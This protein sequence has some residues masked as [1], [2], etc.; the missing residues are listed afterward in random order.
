MSNQGSG[1]LMQEGGGVKMS[2]KEIFFKYMV[3]LPW[4]IVCLAF[5]ITIAYL[6]IRYTVPLYNS[7]ISILIKNN[8]RRSSVP[9]EISLDNLMGGRTSNLSNEIVILKSATLM[10]RV[11]KSMG[12]DVMY[13][14]Q[15]KVKRSEMYTYSPIQAKVLNVKDSAREVTI[16][17]NKVKSKITASWEGKNQVVTNGSLI[18]TTKGDLILSIDASSV[19]NEYKYFIYWKTTWS[20][21]GQLAGALSVK[22]TSKDAAVVQINITCEIPDKGKDVLDQLVREYDKLNIEDKNRIVLNSIQFIEDR[23]A[24]LNGEMDKVEDQ[25]QSFRQQTG[26]I[27]LEIQGASNFEKIKELQEDISNQE[28]VLWNMEHIRNYMSTPEKKYEIV[29]TALTIN[30]ATL[31]S[32]IQNYNSLQLQREQDLKTIPSSH[33]SI[34]T[35]EGQIEKVRKNILEDLTNVRKSAENLKS[36]RRRS[37]GINESTLK[38]IPAKQRVLLDIERQKAIKEKLFVYLLQKR[39]ELAITKAS[40]VGSVTPIDPAVSWG[41]VSPNST[42]IYRLAFIFGFVIPFG[43]IY[44]RDLLNDKILTRQDIT[45]VTNTPLIGEIAHHNSMTRKFVV[46]MKDRSVLAEQFRIIRTNLQFLLASAPSKNPVILVTSSIAGEGKTFASM[47]MS[48]VWAV[49]GKKT[50]I[51]E[52]DLRKPKISKSLNLQRDIGISNYIL[53][54][55]RKEDLPQPITE[56]P[57]LYVIGAGPIPPNPSE[58]IMDAKMDELFTYLRANFDII[59]IDSAPIGLVSDSKILARFA[60]ATLYVVRQR[61]TVK[62]QMAFVDELYTQK[63]LP[64]MGII[65]NDVKIG[66]ANSYYGYGYG[67]GYGYS[68]NYNYSYSY[69]EQEKKGFFKRVKDIVGL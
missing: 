59:I 39:E 57:N 53:G 10:N 64:N 55:A 33:P 25:F 8:E 1:P 26:V 46:G 60:D 51:L 42:N 62:K 20:V 61:Y 6:Y 49:A 9:A 29:P 13:Y 12:L 32:L 40:A 48:A 63:I 11:V 38:S 5:T 7:A 24:I 50:V 67:Y 15:G 17:F 47:N 35:L 65:V 66:G 31:T 56:V 4:F 2:P 21:A 22:Q 44:L 43:L 28:I 58:M 27:D 16:T 45:K 54:S 34:K 30:D 19:V 14:N 41:P 37:Y 23:L 36:D 52:L 69:G 18:S 3:Y 68:Y